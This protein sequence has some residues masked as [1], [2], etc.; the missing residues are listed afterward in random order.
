VA[1]QAGVSGG[2]ISQIENGRTV[3][4]LPVFLGIV[5]SLGGSS[6]DNF[7]FLLEGLLDNNHHG[8]ILHLRSNQFRK[9]R[10]GSQ[11][12]ASYQQLFR[13][14]MNL[15]GVEIMLVTLKPGEFENALSSD[16]LLFAYAIQ[17]QFKLKSQLQQLEVKAGEALSFNGQVPH[18]LTVTEEPVVVLCLH[19]MAK[20]S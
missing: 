15:W 19:L 14:E 2:L 1:H 6:A 5:R 11:K 7:R 20:L 13:E 17:G 10:R 12:Q 3:P 16:A 9:I 18:V 8:S 4:S